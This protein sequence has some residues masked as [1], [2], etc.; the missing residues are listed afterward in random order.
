MRAEKSIDRLAA[1][2]H[3]ALDMDGTIYK[4]GTLFDF[5]KPF[6]AR[7]Q[8]L[9]IGYTFLTNNSSRSARDYLAHLKRLDLDVREDQMFTSGLATIA[10]LRSHHPTYRR[11]YIL[12]TESLKRE[13]S[14]AGFWI[15]SE[16]ASD[17]PDAL[18][19]YSPRT[20]SGV[21]F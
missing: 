13:F 11:L 6:L 18:R 19:S 12:G 1:V 5:T 21:N 20:W 8:E 2:R 10:T 15:V 3:L 14:E 9:G 17:E 4:G 7:M 16:S